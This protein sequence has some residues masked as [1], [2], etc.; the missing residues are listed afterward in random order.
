MGDGIMRRLGLYWRTLRH[1]TPRQVVYQVWNRL[2]GQPRLQWSATPTP[3]DVP[4]IRFPITFTFL[5]QSVTFTDQIDWNYAANGKLWTY[6]LTYFEWLTS[7]TSPPLLEN[8]EGSTAPLVSHDSDCAARLPSP[9]SRRG[10][11]GEV[12]EVNHSK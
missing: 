2:R 5:N 3:A 6:N 10:V 4:S 7:L 11:G 9:F 8:G 12:S 1:L